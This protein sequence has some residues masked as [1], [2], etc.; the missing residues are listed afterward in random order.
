MLLRA[1][2]VLG[3]QGAGMRC[4]SHAASLEELKNLPALKA[5]P[6]L[7]FFTASWCQPC[8]DAMPHLEDVSSRFEGPFLKMAQIDVADLPD[9]AQEF[10]VDSVP[11]FV[12]LRDGH[13][14][15]RLAG[16]GPKDIAEL[17]ERHA[18][19]FQKLLEESR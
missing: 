10:G 18:A 14:V 1:A 12:V 16:Y 15:E 8:R 5:P 6:V 3:Q 13:V 19:A 11:Y 9:A 7:V 2:R 17:A 4:I